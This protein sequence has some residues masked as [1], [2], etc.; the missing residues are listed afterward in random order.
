[1]VV[2]IGLGIPTGVVHWTGQHCVAWSSVC[3]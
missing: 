2:W 3:W 1:L